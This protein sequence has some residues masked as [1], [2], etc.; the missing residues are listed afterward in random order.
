MLPIITQQA[1]FTCLK[2]SG[3][4][5]KEFSFSKHSTPWDFTIPYFW[6]YKPPILW[7]LKWAQSYRIDL[8]VFHWKVELS[9]FPICL[10]Y[11]QNFILTS[12]ELGFGSHV[13]QIQVHFFSK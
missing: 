10:A 1:V 7:T 8:V 11:S 12:S 5:L 6:I 13:V 4:V 9:S 2:I 3:W